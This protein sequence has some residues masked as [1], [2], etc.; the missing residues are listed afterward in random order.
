MIVATRRS[1]WTTHRPG[2]FNTNTFAWAESIRT[3]RAV[4]APF[5]DV[6]LPGIDPSDV[7]EVAA[8]VP[9]DARHAGRTY[10]LTGPAPITP[11]Q[12]ARAIGE[13]LD[14]EIRFQEQSREEARAQ[15]LGFVPEPITDGTLAILGDPLPAEQRVSPHVHTVLG[16]SPRSFTE[17]A[18][19][20]VAAFA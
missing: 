20:D 15:M 7:A 8:A 1:S 11:R 6:A 13:A 2:G 4:T 3:E 10:Q 19:R 17:W 9:R 5:G 14:T 18:A 12:R 16:R